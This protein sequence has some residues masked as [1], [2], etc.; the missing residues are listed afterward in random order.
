M[1]YMDRARAGEEMKKRGLDALIAS[2]P[3]NFYYASGIQPPIPGRPA[4]AVV[5]ADPSVEP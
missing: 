2:T 1:G 3:A 4:I 5:P